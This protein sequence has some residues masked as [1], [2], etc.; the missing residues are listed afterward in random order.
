M[1]IVL[2]AISTLTNRHRICHVFEKTM[3][4]IF[5]FCQHFEPLSQL[6]PWLTP[7]RIPISCPNIFQQYMHKCEHIVKRLKHFI[8]TDQANEK[9]KY[10]VYQTQYN[11]TLLPFVPVSC[12]IAPGRR[13]MQ[14]SPPAN[15]VLRI[16]SHTT[17]IC[18]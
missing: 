3:R 1:I 9:C 10:E 5:L 13:Q 18:I 12:S 11:I 6:C 15:R 17:W 7:F 14:F 8:N 2:G 4:H 16:F